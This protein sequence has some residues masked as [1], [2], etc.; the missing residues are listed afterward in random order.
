MAETKEI[1]PDSK[2]LTSNP[3]TALTQ[4]AQI[5]PNPDNGSNPET[6]AATITSVAGS[7]LSAEAEPSIAPITSAEE[8][9]VPALKEEREILMTPERTIVRVARLSDVPKTA[10]DVLRL[11]AGQRKALEIEEEGF[12]WVYDAETGK[13]LQTCTVKKGLIDLLNPNHSAFDLDACL[14][15]GDLSQEARLI[16]RRAPAN[17][18]PPS[19]LQIVSPIDE[20]ED[21]TVSATKQPIEAKEFPD[22]I[23]VRVVD[24]CK[25]EGN[26]SGI[27]AGMREALKVEKGKL[28]DAF[29]LQGNHLGT[30]NV[31]EGPMKCL[32]P[33][34]QDFDPYGCNMNLLPILQQ[35]DRRIIL[36]KSGFQS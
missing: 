8:R 17:T 6:V 34:N 26:W 2:D 35:N 3:E 28:I 22:R 31:D 33:G 1:S 29:D 20:R 15:G 32:N 18:P 25:S 12:A 9:E 23:V 5:Q 4:P 30:F 19:E 36:K 11:A 13:F 7:V 10:S 16:L 21:R 14:A 24:K 27:S